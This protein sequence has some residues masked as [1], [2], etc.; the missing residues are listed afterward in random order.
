MGSRINLVRYIIPQNVERGFRRPAFPQGYGEN[1]W[2]YFKSQ[3]PVPPKESVQVYACG[4]LCLYVYPLVGIALISATYNR[5]SIQDRT[6]NLAMPYI[7]E[8][9]RESVES[10]AFS[11]VKKS[12]FFKEKSDSIKNKVVNEIIHNAPVEDTALVTF[13]AVWEIL[14]ERV[15]R[16]AKVATVGIGLLLVYRAF[17]RER[18][19]PESRVPSE[20]FPSL[21]NKGIRSIYAQPRPGD[22]SR[23]WS[24][25]SDPV[26]SMSDVSATSSVDQIV[27]SL[28][29]N[30][31]WLCS[32]EYEGTDKVMY[33]I[34]L[35]G[36]MFLS[37]KH[38]FQN[39][40][41]FRYWSGDEGRSSSRNFCDL[42]V[43]KEVFLHPTKDLCVFHVVG[44]HPG[45]EGSYKHLVHSSQLALG[46]QFDRGVFIYPGN[47]V[48]PPTDYEVSSLKYTLPAF[49]KEV[50]DVD[51]PVR[52]GWAYS[53]PSQKGWCGSP[54]VL[55]RQ[56]HCWWGGIHVAASH[57]FMSTTAM[58]D[59]VTRFD[60]DPLILRCR[61]MNMTARPS[62]PVPVSQGCDAAGFEFSPVLWDNN[63]FNGA[64][65]VDLEIVGSVEKIFGQNPHSAHHITKVV[66][67]PFSQDFDDLRQRH[68]GQDY[69]CGPNFRGRLI[70][71]VWREPLLESIKAC[72]GVFNMPKDELEMACDDYIEGVEL[73][74]GTDTFR[75]LSDEE[76]LY[77]VEGSSIRGFDR[78]TSSGYPFFRNKTHLV[79]SDPVK[80]MSIVFKKQLEWARKMLH[81]GF[82]AMPFVS[83]SLK[84][85]PLSAE[86]VN[87]K[88]KARVFMCFPFFFNFLLK[89]YFGPVMAFILMHRQFFECYAGMNV[90]S[91]ECHT[92]YQH[93]SAFGTHNAF[94][95]DAEKW[96]KRLNTT[97][98][99]AVIEIL[100]YLMRVLNYT[101]EQIRIGSGILVSELYH[102]AYCK[103]GLVA[104]SFTDPSGSFLTILHNS[105]GQSVMMRFV[106]RKYY[107]G[108]VFRDHVRLAHVG[109][110]S[111]QCV[112][113]G[114]SAYCYVTVRDEC[115]K[116]G[117][118]FTPGD[119]SDA[120]DYFY[121]ELE[122]CSFLKR[123]LRWNSDL[124]SW[125]AVLDPKSL[126]KTLT[127]MIPGKTSLKD[128][129]S[130][131]LSSVLREYFL[132]GRSEY[133]YML[134]RV[135]SVCV[136]Y[137]IWSGFVQTYDELKLSYGRDHFAVWGDSIDALTESC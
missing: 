97:I 137:E 16:V 116:Y 26:Y 95:A 34:R 24:V 14:Q 21:V 5:E 43:G 6:R 44:I 115:K 121:K 111:L 23:E 13:D 40:G 98:R 75:V 29:K 3:F 81:E 7:T 133:E 107:A 1:W 60:V 38:Y 62:Q 9:I 132:Y 119:K 66:P 106:W 4:L 18:A 105:I 124:S 128:Q 47:G 109:D 117:V 53:V 127:V 125:V 101:D 52:E 41:R 87:S 10:T 42:R 49:T 56:G 100:V 33:A 36:N 104:F 8:V 55:K 130:S 72:E 69:F 118:V 86:K 136:K 96:D 58:G 37:T 76:T 54:L 78:T 11:F 59:E 50:Q 31:L 126:V 57:G 88:N 22:F 129:M 99:L 70:N 91:R 32:P 17:G 30:V 102:F 89:Q 51:L 113:D 93:M 134:L 77:G 65:K 28:K 64:E 94:D 122:A 114:F 135:Q 103:G 131:A 20:S 63:P 120:P 25:A 112:A 71:G 2:N 19:E 90:S 108:Y 61:D 67:T 123:R 82:L 27:S 110:D 15:E 80:G 85:E 39:G 84:D 68:L 83:W 48:V 73:L 79:D 92:F 45:G 35:S 12:G 46:K 74:P